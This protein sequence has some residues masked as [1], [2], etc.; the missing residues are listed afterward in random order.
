MTFTNET[1]AALGGIKINGRWK[2]FD[3]LSEFVKVSSY[4][5]TVR[6]SGWTF[7]IWGGK[8]SGGRSNEWYVES[9]D[10]WDSGKPIPCT[11]LVDALKLI[12]G[13]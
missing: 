6:R 2:Y 13:M 11:S 9:K 3:N 4:E 10:A 5:Y 1:R 7:T 8:K 12:D